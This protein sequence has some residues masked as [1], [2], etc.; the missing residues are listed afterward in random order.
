MRPPQLADWLL[1]RLASGPKRQSLI[2]D[3][4]EQHR[5]GRSTAWYWRQVLHA[6]AASALWDIRQH[7]AF[8]VRTV[9]LTYLFMVPWIFFTG[10]IYGSTKWWMVDH[11]IKG[12][13]AFHDLW[14]L[15][16]APLLTAWCVGAALIGWVVATAHAES[17]AGTTAVAVLALL[18]WTVVYTRPLL[19][20]ANAGLPFFQSVPV[21]AGIAIVAVGMP[22]TLL[23]GSVLAAPRSSTPHQQHLSA[24]VRSC[25]T[26]IRVR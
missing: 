6:I 3:L 9:A 18:P 5:R 25:P 23:M 17:R 22:L 10:F 21:I 4:H 26:A 2:G 20:L 16:Q 19:Q 15:Y 1:H 13:V 24:N 8:A 14:V 7:P 12:S 11:V